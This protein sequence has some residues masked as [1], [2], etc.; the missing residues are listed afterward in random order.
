MLNQLNQVIAGKNSTQK[1]PPI[2]EI[3]FS[4]SNYPATATEGV[5][6]CV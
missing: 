3:L 4:T 1:N 6:T 2:P 5:Y